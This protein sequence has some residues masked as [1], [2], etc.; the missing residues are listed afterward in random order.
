V[1]ADLPEAPAGPNTL[2][3]FTDET[4]AYALALVLLMEYARSHPRE[5][6]VF[7]PFELAKLKAGGLVLSGPDLAG[8]AAVLSRVEGLAQHEP[9]AE[10]A[11]AA[12]LS[13]R[14]RLDGAR[15]VRR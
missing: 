6:F 13:G 7:G 1:D 4:A 11:V 15:A 5:E 9:G 2:R 3:Y 8:P 14:G 10:Q 12:R